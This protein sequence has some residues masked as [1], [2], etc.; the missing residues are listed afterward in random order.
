[1]KKNEINR[2]IKVES[3]D[4]VIKKTIIDITEAKADEVRNFYLK[5]KRDNYIP[6]IFTEFVIRINDTASMIETCTN[7]VKESFKGQEYEAKNIFEQNILKK[8]I[9][10]IV[11]N[12]LNNNF[13]TYKKE[14]KIYHTLFIKYKDSINVELYFYNEQSKPTG[15]I[16]ACYDSEKDD[17]A[18]SVQSNKEMI[19]NFSSNKEMSDFFNI[20][21]Q[22]FLSVSYYMQHFHSEVEYIE[23]DVKD[24]KK[25]SK[26]KTNGGYSQK[27]TLKSKKKKYVIKDSDTF[28]MRKR[29]EAT[30]QVAS[31]LTRGHYRK[32]GKNKVI[33]YIPPTIHKRKNLNNGNTNKKNYEIK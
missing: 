6:P 12:M 24:M 26:N 18:L 27:I 31:W 30:Y 33:K 2:N 21:F 13:K 10:E 1:M 3:Y 32:C 23:I 22:I 19:Y 7:N 4:S 9:S 5:N 11:N 15:M 8:N 20:N 16:E 25:S 17:W 14:K 28:E 29:K